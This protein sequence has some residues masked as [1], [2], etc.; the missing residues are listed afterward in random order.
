MAK[1]IQSTS[2]DILQE[3]VFQHMKFSST[4]EKTHFSLITHTGATNPWYEKEGL[5]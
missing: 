3:K 2:F 4:G 1:Q 5:W